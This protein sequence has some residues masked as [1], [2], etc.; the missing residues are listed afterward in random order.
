MGMFWLRD[1][2]LPKKKGGRLMNKRPQVKGGNAQEGHSDNNVIALQ[3]SKCA[4][5]KRQAVFMLHR[6]ISR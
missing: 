1:Q 2:R 3:Q 4:T 6:T 5:H